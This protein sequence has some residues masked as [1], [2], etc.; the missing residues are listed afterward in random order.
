MRDTY[1]AEVI[2][3]RSFR[4]WFDP[5]RGGGARPRRG[6]RQ[7]PR[8]GAV[9]PADAVAHRRGVPP[10]AE[11][12]DA[13]AVLPSGAAAA[14]CAPPP[15]PGG[16]TTPRSSPSAGAS[17]SRCTRPATPTTTCACST[18]PTAIVLTGDHVLPTITPHISGLVAGADPLNEFFK[19][20]EKVAGLEGVRLALPAHGHPFHDLA[21]RAHD[22]PRPP[23]RAA[24]HP[25]HRRQGARRRHRRGVQPQALPAAL[26]GPDGRERDLRPPR[27]PPPDRRGRR[28][29]TRA[30]PSTTRLVE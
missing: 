19:S 5:Q 27:A 15:P 21:G 20:L 2:T 3:H 7:R 14:S 4:T 10:A 11:A 24:R 9:R 28:R 6:E 8:P 12:A 26:L 17:G 1:G 25:P 16:S 22:D 13:D 23:R 30:A 29:T 18:P